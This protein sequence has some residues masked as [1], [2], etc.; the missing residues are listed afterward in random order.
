[1]TDCFEPLRS[2]GAN[3]LN[4][5]EFSELKD[6]IERK[7]KDGIPGS[8]AAFDEV[9]NAL[10]NIKKG[11]MDKHDLKEAVKTYDFYRSLEIKNKETDR[12]LRFD[13]RKDGLKRGMHSM[14]KGTE[15]LTVGPVRDS[16]QLDIRTTMLELSDGMKTEMDRKKLLPIWNN[17]N[18]QRSIAKTLWDGEHDDAHL[19]TM[20][21]IVEENRNNINKELLANGVITDKLP[22]RIVRTYH[23][24]SRLESTS[25]D[26]FEA[27]QDTLR[28]S[29]EERKIKARDRWVSFLKPRID[30]EKM[31]GDRQSKKLEKVD[32]VK[33][34]KMITDTMNNLYNEITQSDQGF[35]GIGDTKHRFIH[36]KDSDAVV[37]YIEEYGLGSLQH[38]LMSEFRSRSRQLA[39]VRRLGKNPRGMIKKVMDGAIEK[40]ESFKNTPKIPK[41]L[42]STETLYDIARSSLDDPDSNWAKVAGNI[43][44]GLNSVRLGSLIKSQLADL[45]PISSETA[46][47]HGGFIQAM[48]NSIM[49]LAQRGKLLKVD[50]LKDLYDTYFKAAIGQFNRFTSAEDARVGFLSKM[51]SLVFKM[52]GS[53]DWDSVHKI[54][55]MAAT[56]R[57]LARNRD[58][59]FEGMIK[60]DKEFGQRNVNT[61][62]AYD[63]SSEEW[64]AIRKV[65]DTGAD[66]KLYLTPQ[67]ARDIPDE[68]I[69]NILKEEGQKRIRQEDIDDRKKEIERKFVRYMVDTVD[70]GIFYQDAGVRRGLFGST[71][72]GTAPGALLRLMTQ[73]QGYMLSF[74]N[75]SVAR[76]AFGDGAD[77]LTDAFL[78]GKGNVRGL[79]QL[80]G[81]ATV[82]GYAGMAIGYLSRGETPPWPPTLGT[83]VEAFS[84]GA[85]N[86][87]TDL[88]LSQDAGNTEKTLEQL[89]GQ[90]ITEMVQALGLVTSPLNALY[91][92]K[93]SDAQFRKRY[94]NNLFQFFKGLRPNII[95][96]KAVFDYFITNRIQELLSPNY[97]YKRQAE[98]KK[99][100][101][102]YY[103]N[104]TPDF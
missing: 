55:M 97:Y 58:V 52:Q 84:A 76:L 69:R 49:H 60:R 32:P 16:L 20:G 56:F 89:A 21:Q 44:S 90:A 30:R 10:D 18:M 48:H 45:G 102:N 104:P 96:F 81:A 3:I 85:G 39:V 1:M 66:R 57:H 47:L 77:S 93:W 33:F 14:I 79:A 11:L 41:I 87:Y 61:L 37:D 72:A 46:R 24:I 92:G 8:K 95:F 22:N 80:M 5:K 53:E 59:S 54:G 82:L 101:Q 98:L 74:Y 103:I 68:D 64:N 51:S 67:S 25:S 62:K 43:S 17:K 31:F 83:L 65:P 42:K 28:L 4:E 26:V 38:Q 7:I 12:L 2:L 73:Y 40:S 23:V 35:D 50:E 91:Q 6:R 19:N 88:I 36:F 78:R 86:R 13:K 70:H 71:N 100:G 9:T 94:V 63:I 75:K 99:E 27:A 34:E 15:H 29:A